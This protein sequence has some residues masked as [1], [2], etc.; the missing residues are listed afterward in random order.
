MLPFKQYVRVTG[1]QNGEN[2]DADSIRT[3]AC[4][5]A[6]IKVAGSKNLHLKDLQGKKYPMRIVVD[7]IK[8][9]TE[10]GPWNH[11]ISE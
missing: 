8:P 2:L 6:K 9:F 3:D 11:V 1:D 10:Q 7:L 4:G 5:E